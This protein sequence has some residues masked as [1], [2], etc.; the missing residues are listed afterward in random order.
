MLSRYLAILRITW[1]DSLAY[2]TEAIVWMLVDGS[3]LFVMVYLW[4]SIY[5]GQASIAGYDLP[6]MITY[7]VVVT[8]LGIVV[9]AHSD[10]EVVEQIRDGLIAP[11]LLKP[12]PHIVFI[13][14]EDIGWKI[15]KTLLFLPVFGLALVWLRDYITVPTDPLVW[16]S[17]LA[18]LP[19]AY[20]L[21]FLIAYLVGLTTFW[22]QE[23][24]SLTHVKELL[25]MLLGGAMAP[26]AL[27]P[28]WLQGV[29]AL[30]PFQYIYAFPVGIYLGQVRGAA[31]VQ[32]LAAQAAWIA[33]A[34][35]AYRLMWRAGTR[36][37]AV[38][39]G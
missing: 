15:M 32:G 6:Q 20:V 24:M 27:F 10:N 25:A 33:V 17:L 16:L 26:L 31:V 23:A 39:G 11:Y 22:L 28:D 34:Y 30:L 4:R 35:L 38:V 2:R 36:R 19:L 3:P 13:L 8:L 9:A 7:Y 37:F 5:A 14:L 12:F 29:A 18:A 21:F 1:V